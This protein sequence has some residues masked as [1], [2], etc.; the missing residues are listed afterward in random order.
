MLN[1][2]DMFEIKYGLK[3]DIEQRDGR[4]VICTLGVVLLL[5]AWLVYGQ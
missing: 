1:Q 2:D 5:L 3:P 4:L